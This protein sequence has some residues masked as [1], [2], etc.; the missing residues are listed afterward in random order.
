VL[1]RF[2]SS[3]WFELVPRYAPD[4]TIHEQDPHE[5]SSQIPVDDKIY[6]DRKGTSKETLGAPDFSAKSM[7]HNEL[8]TKPTSG[9]GSGTAILDE[10]EAS[11]RVTNRKSDGR[12]S[13]GIDKQLQQLGALST[14][15]PRDRLI[16]EIDG[17]FINKVNERNA[18]D[19]K[20]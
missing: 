19:L 1:P 6:S 9:T 4:E 11:N 2:D 7:S 12:K 13:D 3:P 17:Q 5:E 15:A 20:T 8:P 14:F 10:D 16:S 18:Y